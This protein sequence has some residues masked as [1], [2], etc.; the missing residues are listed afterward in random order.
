[1]IRK[2]EKRGGSNRFVEFTA[3]KSQ[4]GEIGPASV[5]RLSPRGKRDTCR[6]RERDTRSN[7]FGGVAT[8]KCSIPGQVTLLP[9]D[10]SRPSFPPSSKADSGR[11][12]SVPRSE[13]RPVTS[14]ARQ[15]SA[16]A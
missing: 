4:A 7:R 10:K 14:R 13:H 3:G 9:G 16:K 6:L 5:A 11:V 12:T 1:M 15:R 2:R 8:H